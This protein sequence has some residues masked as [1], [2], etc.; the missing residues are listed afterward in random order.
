MQDDRLI[1]VAIHTYDHAT[2]LR[3]LLEGEGIEV[4]F[5]NVN[6][7]TPVVSSGVRVRIHEKDLPLALRV[8]ENP[9]IFRSTDSER[10]EDSHY[11]LVPVDFKPYSMQAAE[12]AVRIAAAHHADVCLLH[13][14]IDPNQE[15]AMQLTANLN[16][17]VGTDETE[18]RRLESDSKKMLD[19]FANSLLDKM[20]SGEL[21]PARLCCKVVEGVPED[22]IMEYAG[23]NPPLLVVMGTRGCIAKE[24]QLIGSVTAEVLDQCHNSVLAIP[25]GCDSTHASKM[26]HV[27]FFSNLE[28]E[29]MLA[30][31]SLCRIFPDEHILITLVHI[32]EKKR[33]LFSRPADV[34][35]DSL[36]SYC[37]EHYPRFEFAKDT[38][39]VNVVKTDEQ[40]RD[41][42]I[43]RYNPD[44]IVIP[45]KRKNAFTRLF[46]PSLAHRVLFCT[47]APVLA[48]P[49]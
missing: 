1:T 21:P 46:S 39:D 4:T 47:E 10:Q 2:E 18:R 42:I 38:V 45:N 29:D 35:L 12:L 37:K 8:I 23:I 25:D 34:D 32:P 43:A 44:L 14:Y 6:L 9:H 26:G 19:D 20:R 5:Q 24:Q 17:A 16:Y 33:L 15:S 7:Q 48:I 49:V 40:L 11:I 22:S 27:I 28:Q 30:I 3:A 41:A 36:L 13:S 31:D